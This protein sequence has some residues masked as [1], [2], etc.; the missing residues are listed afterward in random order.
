MC[1]RFCKAKKVSFFY[2]HH[3]LHIGWCAENEFVV[4][5]KS[6]KNKM[7][8]IMYS[9]VVHTITTNERAITLAAMEEEVKA[10]FLF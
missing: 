7:M 10:F 6:I 4:N 9:I 2:R 1:V 8:V 5:E 3:I